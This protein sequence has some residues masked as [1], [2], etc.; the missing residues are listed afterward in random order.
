VDQ[1]TFDAAEGLARL[2]GTAA[3]EGLDGLVNP[4]WF[5]NEISERGS[6]AFDDSL[7]GANPLTAYNTLVTICHGD[8]HAENI[9]CTM[10]DAALPR[11]VLIDFETTHEAHICRDFTRLEASL[12]TETIAWTDAQN[13]ELLRW[14]GVALGDVVY[15]PPAYTDHD[16]D[17][18]CVIGAARELRSVVASC[19]Q[20]RWPLV[21]EEYELGL[22]AALLPVVRYIVLPPQRRAL[23]LLLAAHVATSLTMRLRGRPAA[24]AAG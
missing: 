13:I 16:R 11:A 15:S 6:R 17:L 5:V 9:L 22:L 7:Y 8:F 18:A 12:L 2:V 19:G 1:A 24:L 10:L 4:L 14:F 21:P 20:P 23:A 3:E